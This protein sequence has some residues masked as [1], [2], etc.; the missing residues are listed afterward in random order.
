MKLPEV[1]AS[2]ARP[3]DGAVEIR[4]DKDTYIAIVPSTGNNQDTYDLAH[5]ICCAI[6]ACAGFTT[7]ELME[8]IG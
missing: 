8:K 2:V 6:N 5:H 7:E 3:G 4:T 1:F